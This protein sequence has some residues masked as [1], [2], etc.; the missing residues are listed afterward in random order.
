MDIVERE[1]KMIF[2]ESHKKKRPEME[3]YLQDQARLTKVIVKE[4]STSNLFKE[5]IK[6]C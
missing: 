6:E 2:H 4:L 5:K 3:I 1:K